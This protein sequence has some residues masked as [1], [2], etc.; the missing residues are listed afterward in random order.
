[1]N[2]QINSTI[3][4]KNFLDLTRV[5]IKEFYNLVSNS[6]MNKEIDNSI[7]WELLYLRELIS[8]KGSKRISS[9]DVNN[10][11]RL[12]FVIKKD[13]EIS[14]YFY[15]R[16]TNKNSK[17]TYE[18]FIFVNDAHLDKQVIE[19]LEN[20]LQSIKNKYYTST[21]VFTLLISTEK[22]KLVSIL[23]S[24]KFKLVRT[25]TQT[26]KMPYNIYQI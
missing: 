26:Y 3:E 18:L 19:I 13:N 20:Y 16:K 11:M 24:S 12:D 10:T 25:D 15:I 21:T 14:G 2:G 5:E 6:D 4:I 23:E 7:L 17:N 1:M 22:T 9:K 8:A